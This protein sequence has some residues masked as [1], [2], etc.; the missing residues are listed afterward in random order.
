MGRK[1]GVGQDLA[2]K[3][4]QEI[5]EG[6][7]YIWGNNYTHRDLKPDNLLLTVPVDRVDPRRALM[8]GS[9]KISDFGFARMLPHSVEELD[10]GSSFV[11]TKLYMSPDALSRTAKLKDLIAVDIW[12]TGIQ[13][14]VTGLIEFPLPG[15]PH[16]RSCNFGWKV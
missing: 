7:S 6:L 13:F 4:L 3:C 1:T 2:R 15:P 8:L 12:A 14:D 16:P 11:G 10:L 5:I 9:L